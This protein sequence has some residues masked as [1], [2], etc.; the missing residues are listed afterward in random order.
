[1]V[2]VV[3]VSGLAAIGIATIFLL[4]RKTDDDERDES[5][6]E[7]APLS[8]SEYW[9]SSAMEGETDA[10]IFSRCAVSTWGAIGEGLVDEADAEAVQDYFLDCSRK[11]GASKEGRSYYRK[12][13]DRVVR[14]LSTFA[15]RG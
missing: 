12:D 8:K 1:M 10:E 11:A 14:Y 3:A 2:L 13:A 6:R 15:M 5:L 4:G 9:A 7:K